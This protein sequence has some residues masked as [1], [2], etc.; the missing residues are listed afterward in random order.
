MFFDFSVRPSLLWASISLVSLYVVRVIKRR[1]THK[2][3]P[4][5]MGL[6]LIG[7]LL[8]LSAT[9]WKEFE[10]WKDQYGTPTRSYSS[11]QAGLFTVGPLVYIEAPGQKILVLNTHKVASELLDHRGHIYS[12]R[13]RMISK[14]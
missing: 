12:D 14:C 1:A 6:P 13:P 9:P 4:G 7:N 2:L 3:P 10:V 8:S 11:S 5:P